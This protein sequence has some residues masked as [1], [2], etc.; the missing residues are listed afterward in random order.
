MFHRRAETF[1][2]C[3][4]VPTGMDIQPPV[5]ASI[6]VVVLMCCATVIVMASLA[7]RFKQRELQHRER[8]A[9]IEKGAALPVLEEPV[10]GPKPFNPRTY[11]LRGL[12]WFFIGAGILV[13]FGGIAMNSYSQPRAWERVSQANDAR[14]HGATDDQVRAI[15]NER[16]ADGPPAAIG[17]I[18]LIPMGV[19]LAYLI[20]WRS[21]R[22]AS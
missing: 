11:L 17:L 21:E 8:M 19:G 13:S 6:F 15:M 20:T 14:Q 22:R 2:E 16:Y 10:R 3:R 5:L 1:A 4:E 9:A 18:G 7:T 12:V